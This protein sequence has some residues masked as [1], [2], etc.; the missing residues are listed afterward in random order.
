MSVQTFP[1]VLTDKL[2]A[3]YIPLELLQ[4]MNDL[5]FFWFEMWIENYAVLKNSMFNTSIWVHWQHHTL[6][7]PGIVFHIK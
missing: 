1:F 7:L 2:Q 3:F 4:I 5:I 6:I